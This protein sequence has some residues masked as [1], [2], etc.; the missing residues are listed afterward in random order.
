MFPN[1]GPWLGEV[2]VKGIYKAPA[3]KPWMPS[4]G[5][6]K[7]HLGAAGALNLT[8]ATLNQALTAPYAVV[9]FGSP[10]CPFCVSYKPVFE[11]VAAAQS[12]DR[13]LMAIVDANEAPQAATTFKLQSL[14][15]TVFL[16]N[17]KEV[18]RVEGGMM[19]EELQAKISSFL[20]GAAP[21]GGLSTGAI[22]G[23]GAGIAAVG[24][25]AYFAFID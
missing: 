23:I 2:K 21:G 20:G 24:T 10:K 14:P 9:D 4:R 11:E 15:T 22:L 13:V 18:D 1:K 19:K 8:D 3:R 12:G 16:V 25:L 7:S 17:G 6:G 5:R